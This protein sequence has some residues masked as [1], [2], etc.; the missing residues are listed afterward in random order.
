MFWSTKTSG[1]TLKDLAR[2]VERER[3]ADFLPFVSY[4]PS[5]RTYRT[6]DNA[7]GYLYEIEPVAFAGDSV[8]QAIN[9]LIN[10]PFG[11]ASTLQLILFADPF[12]GDFLERFLAVKTRLEPLVRKNAV[13]FMKHI[14]DN[15]S[16]MEQLY[17]IPIRNFR[18]FV[19]VK[20][21]KPLEQDVVSVLE[22]ALKR[23]GVRRV[24]PDGD[25]GLL[26][27]MRRFFSD[28]REARAGVMDGA[29]R[30]SH[31]IIDAGTP[32]SF[33][34][35]VVRFGAHFGRCLTPQAMPPH[36]TPQMA[37]R[38]AGGMMG[39][40]DD[41]EQIT[42][43]FLVSLNITF[44]DVASEIATKSQIVSAQRAGGAIA[45]EIGKM[46]DEFHWAVDTAKSERF[47]RVI[48]SIWVFGFSEDEAR[49]NAARVRR[50]YET[51]SFALQ[52]ESYLSKPLFIASL[53]F[54]LY[55]TGANLKTL[56]RDFIMPAS[57]AAVL[58]PVQGDFKG[59]GRP[60]QVF[61]GRKGQIAGFDLF[62]PRLNNH[63]FLVSAESGAGKS[64]LLNN[65]C[66]QY[67]AAGAAIR[68]VD[69]GYS[70]EKNCRLLGGRFIDVGGE[71]VVLN[72]FDIAA[73]DGED[74][75][76]AIQSAADVLGLMATSAAGSRL[77]EAQVN[78]LKA[79][80]RWVFREGRQILGVDAAREYLATYPQFAPE[81]ERAA[82][83]VLE[84]EAHLLAF[85][86]QPYCSEGD[87]GRFFNGKSSLDI[88]HDDFV[89][90]EL[91]RLRNYKQLFSVIV[92]QVLN[93]VTQDL[94]LSAR[95]RE[96][97]ILFEEAAA[98]LK[99]SM[100][101]SMATTFASIIEAGF[102][103]ARKYRGAFGIVLQ[104]VLDLPSFGD[105]GAV[106]WENAATKFLLQG[107]SYAAAA[108]KKI[109]PFEGF[110]LELLKSVRNNKPH[111]SELFVDSPLGCGVARL[112]V[113]PHSYWINTSDPR[114]VA[115]FNQLLQYG[116]TPAQAIDVLVDGADD[117]VLAKRIEDQDAIRR[118]EAAADV[119][120][121]AA[122]V[123]AE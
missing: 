2:M 70:Y 120:L 25:Q 115:R 76:L 34:G 74:R 52:E 10:I 37:N 109:I 72:P 61:I 3:F 53:P 56:D 77:S 59:S 68:I 75:D 106:V 32:I 99:G 81:I 43:P 18:A 23:F 110:A 17:G 119:A 12:I 102:R 123:A 114:D 84:D 33:D 8:I 46:V 57:S 47:V 48:P 112:V 26:A 21:P 44:G 67:Y 98:F 90:L 69:I 29:R 14:A 104:S 9:G 113:D 11:D 96:R 78:L 5:S 54:G 65:L 16:G 30:L 83:N 51:Q 116:L 118:R 89:V 103:R 111:Y 95:E 71:Q 100:A 50:L 108:D 73:G 15:Q 60:V 107:Q 19:A 87:Y 4:E 82:A 94:Y 28:M 36:L 88:A 1:V 31:Q 38:L 42:G 101:G 45:R 80:A 86:L 64:F 49:D 121:A 39:L 105:V 24:E 91:E 13:A 22:E 85:N 40:M 55:L 27:L 79:A 41:P 58:A 20:N 6:L 117:R 35:N 92:C 66:Y 63:N 7:H 122:K 97:F 62:D 93:A